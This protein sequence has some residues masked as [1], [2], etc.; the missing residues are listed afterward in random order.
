MIK[1]GFEIVLSL[2]TGDSYNVLLMGFR[3]IRVFLGGAD[4][5]H[6]VML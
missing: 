5:V 1:M 2:Y 4:D 6:G 3:D